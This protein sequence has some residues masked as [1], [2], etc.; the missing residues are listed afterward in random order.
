MVSELG[1]LLIEMDRQSSDVCSSNFNGM[2]NIPLSLFSSSLNLCDKVEEQTKTRK[3]ND[4]ELM[5]IG[6]FY[7]VFAYRIAA[8]SATYDKEKFDKAL[9]IVEKGMDMVYGSE[10]DLYLAG[11]SMRNH[12]AQLTEKNQKK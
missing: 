7:A 2:N 4:I 3:L 12:I 9:S 11:R 10:V 8:S 6:K 1:E 5:L